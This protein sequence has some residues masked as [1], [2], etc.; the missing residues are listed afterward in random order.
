MAWAFAKLGVKDLPLLQ[1]I[2]AASLAILAEFDPQGIANTVWAFAKCDFGHGPLFDAIAAASVAQ[3]TEFTPQDLA[4]TVWAFSVL[5]VQNDPLIHAIAKEA[6]N[7]ISETGNQSLAYLVDADLPLA[8]A[9]EALRARMEDLAR[10][11]VNMLPKHLAALPAVR[12]LTGSVA[13]ADLAALQVDNLGAVGSRSVLEKLGIG[14]VPLA[15]ESV[16]EER[17]AERLAAGP[18][19]SLLGGP[20][21]AER[22]RVQSE[23]VHRRVFGFA[24]FRFE[25]EGV[26]ILEGDALNE[27]GAKSFRGGASRWLQPTNLSINRW[28]ERVLCAEFQLVAEICDRLDTA[29][30]GGMEDPMRRLCVTGSLRLLTST[31]PCLSCLSMLRQMQLLLPSLTLEVSFR[32]MSGLADGG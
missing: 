15:F 17:I 21:A 3:I 7:K 12:P 24:T 29:M 16:A 5:K 32:S 13:D 22:V 10:Q 28:V 6:L 27:N 1:S 19:P 8:A 26:V 23:L 31:S 18:P 9:A 20:A 4:S 30:R 14:P 11:V 2:S 25:F